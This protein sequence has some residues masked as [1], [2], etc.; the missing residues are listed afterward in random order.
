MV[1][2]ENARKKY[3]HTQRVL[4]DTDTQ[5]VILMLKAMDEKIQVEK[6]EDERPYKDG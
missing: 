5:C 3:T 1:N 4:L 2:G 6:R